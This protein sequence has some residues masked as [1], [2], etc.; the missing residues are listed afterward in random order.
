MIICLYGRLCRCKVEGKKNLEVQ[1]KKK[2][3]STRIAQPTIRSTR[4]V[5]HTFITF[6]FNSN[7]LLYLELSSFLSLSLFERQ[8]LTLSLRRTNPTNHIKK[9]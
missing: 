5:V 7:F 2:H 4:T 1:S 3:T 6:F 8:P 9:K